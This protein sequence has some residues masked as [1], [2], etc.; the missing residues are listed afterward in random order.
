MSITQEETENLRR[1]EIACESQGGVGQGRVLGAERG[2]LRGRRRQPS[3]FWSHIEGAESYPSRG[4][5]KARH[6]SWA[7][8]SAELGFRIPAQAQAV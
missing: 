4:A 2:Q 3:P 5:V 6:G 7:L 8:R 1:R